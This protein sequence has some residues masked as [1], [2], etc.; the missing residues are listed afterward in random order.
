MKTFP[1]VA[2]LVGVLGSGVAAK[3]RAVISGP[4]DPGAAEPGASAEFR[5]KLQSPRSDIRLRAE[6]LLPGG[7]YV[8]W[9][10]G[11]PAAD[12]EADEDGEIRA[13]LKTKKNETPLVSDAVEIEV[14][15]VS[16]STAVLSTLI[17]G[18]AVPPALRLDE[19]TDLARAA[20]VTGK[21]RA[22]LVHRADGRVRFK[23]SVEGVTPG[24]YDVA[25]DGVSRGTL[26][27]PAGGFA[28]IRFA[29]GG[30]DPADLPLDFPVR[31]LQV[32]LS[33][34]GITQFSGPMAVQM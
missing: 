9:I 18:T 25:I 17:S 29:S 6:G 16:G 24:A 11:V 2:M 15:V 8:L 27:V 3:D 22:R 28:E 31:G 30:D 12:L 20:A 32:D 10:D 1:L 5:M 4:L 34:G 23:V 21:A 19:R 14:A 7:G 13:R 33:L 26:T